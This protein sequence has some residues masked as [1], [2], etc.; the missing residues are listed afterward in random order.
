MCRDR[1]RKGLLFFNERL[2]VLPKLRGTERLNLISDVRRA[3]RPK[4]GFDLQ[5]T[6]AR[7]TGLVIVAVG[8][9]VPVAGDAE[10]WGEAV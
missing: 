10:R 9:G 2:R 4:L 5:A 1:R 7:Q 8:T 3:T 6:V